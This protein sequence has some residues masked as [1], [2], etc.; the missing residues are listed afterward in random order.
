MKHVF[1]ERQGAMYSFTDSRVVR[2]ADESLRPADLRGNAAV[3]YVERNPIFY[4]GIAI[5]GGCNLDCEYCTAGATKNAALER[6]MT[7]DQFE[8]AIR[9]LVDQGLAKVSLTGGEPF[10]HPHLREI[11]GVLGKYSVQSVMNTNGTM[12]NSS[13]MQ[14]MIDNGLQEI[15]ISVTDIHDDG[16]I[17][18]DG[19]NRA[20]ARWRGL[21]SAVEEF[22]GRLLFRASTV[23]TR[24]VV[25]N[26][27][28][29]EEIFSDMGVD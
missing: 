10:T 18:A 17:Y 27:F 1:V 28:E 11:Y 25:E 21:S 5:T 6:A 19:M 26:L 29:Y 7:V 12:L 8:T 14:W 2:V 24:R 20:P 15:D 16:A 22:Q 23:L 3:T 9:E 4:A 13:L